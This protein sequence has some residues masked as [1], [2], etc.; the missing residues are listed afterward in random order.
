M[1]N[2]NIKMTSLLVFGNFFSVA[3]N[4]FQVFNKGKRRS[5]ITL[6]FQSGAFFSG[7]SNLKNTGD[8]GLESR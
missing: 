8:T 2:T 1:Q 6:D 5:L 3:L 7:I 4:L